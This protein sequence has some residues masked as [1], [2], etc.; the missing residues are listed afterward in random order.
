MGNYYS[1]TANKACTA[2][3]NF[4]LI[5][6]LRADLESEIGAIELY[7]AH[8]NSITDAGVRAVLI[9]IINDEHDHV[10]QL[11]ELLERWG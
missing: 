8:L 1:D 4:E 6:K 10:R 5:T 7:Q 9:E 2:M 11:T 3:N